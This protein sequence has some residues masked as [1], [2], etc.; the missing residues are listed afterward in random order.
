VIVHCNPSGCCYL[1]S[2]ILVVVL[3]VVPSAVATAVIA[4]VFFTNPVVP[5][6]VCIDCVLD[7]AV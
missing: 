3:M 5:Y 7:L 4:V 6:C 1:D 2:L